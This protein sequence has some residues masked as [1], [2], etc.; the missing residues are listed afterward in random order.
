MITPTRPGHKG[1]CVVLFFSV[2]EQF[3]TQQVRLKSG[4]KKPLQNLSFTVQSNKKRLLM[5]LWRSRRC[6]KCWGKCYK[7]SNV[8]TECVLHHSNNLWLQERE[9]CGEKVPRLT[10]WLLLNGAVLEKVVFILLPVQKHRKE[11]DSR[12]TSV[13]HG[14]M[15]L[16]RRKRGGRWRL[17]KTQHAQSAISDISWCVSTWSV[18]GLIRGLT[19]SSAY[20]P[21]ICSLTR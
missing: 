13:W 15:E 3:I 8:C 9:R 17:K 4:S 11:R 5:A 16:P 10:Y 20:V 14:P 6:L 7:K 19:V 12:Y 21:F 18:S 2:C 1:P